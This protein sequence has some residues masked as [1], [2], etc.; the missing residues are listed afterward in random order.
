M[1]LKY[2]EN[3]LNLAFIS[4]GIIESLYLFFFY[5]WERLAYES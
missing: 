4:K 1:D 2:E 3:I 5:K